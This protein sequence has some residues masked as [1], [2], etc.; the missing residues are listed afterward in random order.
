MDAQAS[1]KSTCQIILLDFHNLLFGMMVVP[2][3]TTACFSFFRA[4][5]LRKCVTLT[6]EYAYTILDFATATFSDEGQGDTEVNSPSRCRRKVQ[7]TNSSSP[8]CHPTDWLSWQKVSNYSSTI[9][10]P[11]PIH[12]HPVARMP[13]YKNPPCGAIFGPDILGLQTGS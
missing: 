1:I 6:T 11:S 4:G 13:Q 9:Q 5:C 2:F 10:A 12:E 8:F 3:F 7:P